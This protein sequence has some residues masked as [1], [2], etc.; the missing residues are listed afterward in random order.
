MSS[1]I[2][3]GASLPTMLGGCI[4]FLAL[5]EVDGIRALS[6]TTVCVCAVQE[7]SVRLALVL[8][9]HGSVPGTLARALLPSHPFVNNWPCSVVYPDT[10]GNHSSKIGILPITEFWMWGVIV[11][12]DDSSNPFDTLRFPLYVAVGRRKHEA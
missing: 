7:Y 2:G 12:F 9:A 6:L 3:V 1:F 4:V 10:S 11:A 8:P 5:G